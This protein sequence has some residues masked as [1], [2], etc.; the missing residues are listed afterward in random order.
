MLFSLFY[1]LPL[2]AISAAYD[3]RLM[4]ESTSLVK[5]AQD[6]VTKVFVTTVVAANREVSAKVLSKLNGSDI[7]STRY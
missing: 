6:T 2:V 5:P 4:F 3:P 1:F 7:S